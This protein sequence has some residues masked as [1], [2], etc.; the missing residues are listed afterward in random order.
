MDCIKKYYN[1]E[2]LSEYGMYA[3]GKKHGLFLSLFSK[4]GKSGSEVLYDN[5]KLKKAKLIVPDEKIIIDLCDDVVNI[6]QSYTECSGEMIHIEFLKSNYK[7]NYNDNDLVN[8]RARWGEK[9]RNT[10]D[11]YVF[12]SDKIQ[13]IDNNNIKYLYYDN[14]FLWVA[15]DEGLNKYS[16][17]KKEFINE[18]RIE[19][20]NIPAGIYI[21]SGNV[22]E[23]KFSKKIIIN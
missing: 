14:D 17:A 21:L 7:D 4:T 1:D 9:W 13:S 18:D 16:Y 6:K 3:D 15:T 2:R 8:I 19:I 23:S 10:L 11:K 20:K 22:N 12:N 5:G